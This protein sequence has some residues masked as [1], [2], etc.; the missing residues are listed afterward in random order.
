MAGEIVELPKQ[1]MP[2]GRWCL[3]A[4]YRL[5]VTPPIVVNATNVVLRARSELPPYVE[6]LQLLTGD[7]LT[8]IDSGVMTYHIDDVQQREGESLAEVRQRVLVR[9]GHAVNRIVPR[10]RIA[11]ANVGRRHDA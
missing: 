10:A 4:L 6:A 5:P 11:Y 3:S 1:I 2:N 9:Y 8:A 7:E